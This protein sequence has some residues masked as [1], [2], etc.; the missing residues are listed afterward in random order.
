MGA[1][2]SS[3][4]FNAREVDDVFQ[5]IHVWLLSCCRFAAEKSFHTASKVFHLAQVVKI[6]H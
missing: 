2:S 5:T 1:R 6:D 4:I 3:R